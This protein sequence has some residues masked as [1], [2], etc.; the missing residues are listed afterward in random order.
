MQPIVVGARHRRGKT[1]ILIRKRENSQAASRKEHGHVNAFGVHRFQLHCAGPTTLRVAS[2]NVLVLV[3]IAA[4]VGRAAS[5]ARVDRY[6][7]KNG[8]EIA[9]VVRSPPPRRLIAK[10]RR[11]VTLPEIGGLHDVHVAVEN[12]ESVFCHDDIL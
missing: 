8:A 6:L 4:A 7:W 9:H 10:L 5:P 11:N 1:R 12:S 2:I 3:E